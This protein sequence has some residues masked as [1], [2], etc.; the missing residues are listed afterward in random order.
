MLRRLSLLLIVTALA[1]GCSGDRRRTVTLGVPTTIQDSGLLDTVLVEFQRANP[2]L[3]LRYIA[4]GSGE[5]LS[6]GR[7]GDLDVL[8][9]HSPDAERE[10]IEAGHGR[11][12][13]RVMENDFVIVGPPSDP[14]GLRG[15]QDAVAGLARIAGTNVTFLSRGDDSGTHRKELELWV[16]AGREPGGAGYRESGRGMGDVLRAASDS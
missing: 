15:M 10:F 8:L 9:A 14:A 4:A 11:D 16:A 12:R 3:R 7:H 6:L 5:L 1:T 2:D 13:R